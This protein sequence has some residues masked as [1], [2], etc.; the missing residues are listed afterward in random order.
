LKQ[1]FSPHY[2][3]RN[4]KAL[5]N[6]KKYSKFN[7]IKKN[8]DVLVCV[9]RTND[10]GAANYFN[11]LK[12]LLPSNVVY[13]YRGKSNWPESRGFFNEL[14]RIIKDYLAYIYLLLRWNYKIIHI[15]TFFGGH[16]VFRDA[17]F[18][19]FAKMM[20]KKSIVFFRGWDWKFS[21]K[22]KNRIFRLIKYIY[23]KP[24]ALIVLS[25]KEKRQLQSWGY[26]GL[27]FSETTTVDW[28]L[29]QGVAAESITEKYDRHADFNLLFLSRV[30]K[31]KGI[32]E[33]IDAFQILQRKYTGLRFTIAGKGPEL[34]IIKQYIID[35]NI[36]NIIF[37]GFVSGYEKAYVYQNAHIFLFPSYSEG[38]PNAVLEAFAF[39]LPVIT[40]EVGGLP[41]IFKEPE[42]GLIVR[43]KDKIH[44]AEIIDHLL[45]NPKIMKKISTNNYNYARQTFVSTVVAKRLHDIYQKLL[46]K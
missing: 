16:G 29:V 42:N 37:T 3:N 30:H 44:L 27:I 32:Y 14:S 20:R 9:P 8:G 34:D 45:T 24:D 10:G 7:D 35:K 1:T 39:G 22:E 21:E 11:A 33:A 19:I 15:N 28:H 18:I 23:L 25:S 6:M 26:N 5:G 41:D 43:K 36:K 12:D 46:F 17:V 4:I 38:M 31:E 40:T 2:K 13:F